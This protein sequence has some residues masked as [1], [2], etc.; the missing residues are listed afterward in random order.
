LSP[1]PRMERGI[2]IKKGL[3]LLHTHIGVGEE[4]KLF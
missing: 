2:K 4:E 3:A 1:S